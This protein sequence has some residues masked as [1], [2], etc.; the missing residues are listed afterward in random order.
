MVPCSCG[1]HK[2]VGGYV[3]NGNEVINSVGKRKGHWLYKKGGTYLLLSYYE[4]MEELGQTS[5]RR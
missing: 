1:I 3:R 5:Q 4:A 2:L